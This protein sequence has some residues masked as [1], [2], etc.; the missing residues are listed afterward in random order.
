MSKFLL[1]ETTTVTFECEADS[2]I[3]ALNKLIFSKQMDREGIIA[4][5]V[6]VDWNHGDG[7][8][9]LSVEERYGALLLAI[10]KGHALADRTNK[11]DR[12]KVIG[13]NILSNIKDLGL[14]L[15]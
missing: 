9:S 10:Q 15:G 11:I 12:H 8:L 6:A 3:E 1:K 5:S 13:I 4:T 7:S 2:R 14:S